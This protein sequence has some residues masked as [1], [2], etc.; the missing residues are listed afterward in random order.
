[1]DPKQKERD[2]MVREQLE[3]RGLRN[4][5]V[6]D[7][8]RSVP[9]HLFVNDNLQKHAYA[10]RPLTIGHYQTISQ[11]YVVALMCDQL[12]LANTDKVLE[13]G[14]GSGYAAAVLSQLCERVITIERIPDLAEK[15]RET[16]A[17]A[18]CSN[19]T[20]HCG[21]GTLGHQE[22]APFD[23]ILVSAAAPSVPE[24]YKQQ[25]RAGGRLI[26]PAG[27]SRS[28][29]SLYRVRKKSDTEFSTEDLGGVAFVPLIGE[30]GWQET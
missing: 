29:Q 20:V 13:I 10:D 1:M 26:I 30:K 7:A 15:A 4:A 23:A 9:R 3:R 22:D 28:S 12:E 2:T 25:L 24:A 17:Q 21:D 14:T 5:R 6:L 18:G 11:P 8:M 16:L 27:H 19:V